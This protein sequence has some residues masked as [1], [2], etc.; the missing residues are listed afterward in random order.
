MSWGKRERE[1]SRLGLCMSCRT[2]TPCTTTPLP[3]AT[4]A[5]HARTHHHLE[6]ARRQRST[7]SV[8]GA[9]RPALQGRTHCN[10]VV[11]AGAGA[12]TRM[13]NSWS[14]QQKGR[15]GR[16]GPNPP[17]PV[18]HPLFC[19]SE[20]LLLPVCPSRGRCRLYHYHCTHCPVSNPNSINSTSPN[21]NGNPNPS[22][23]PNPTCAI[24]YPTSNHLCTNPSPPCTTHALPRGGCR[25]ARRSMRWRGERGSAHERT[26]T[27]QHANTRHANRCQT[28]YREQQ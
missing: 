18:K 24:P 2:H 5:C 20:P 19:W 4:A 3:P 10:T 17:P 14:W 8:G 23:N 26:C 11:A 16:T 7:R 22:H 15:G 21:S 28:A 6:Q 27:C 25:V 12:H 13:P 9:P 1:Y